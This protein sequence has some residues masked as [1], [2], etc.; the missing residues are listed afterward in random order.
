MASPTQVDLRALAARVAGGVELLDVRMVKSSAEHLGFP[1]SGSPLSYDL[2]IQPTAHFDS[3]SQGLVVST[4]F[5]LE[6]DQETGEEGSGRRQIANVSFTLVALFETPEGATYEP[7]ELE[8]F[9]A[10]TGIFC[11]YPYAREY[12]QDVTG[13][14]G[15]PP[16]TL[17][18]YR[19]PAPDDTDSE[20]GDSPEQE[21]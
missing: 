1:V 13:R 20:S 5:A 12:V 15:L 21:K 17:G 8:S 19:V 10:T 2:D 6:M 7:E 14:L 16:L 9:G 4:E 18:V 11:L 3:D